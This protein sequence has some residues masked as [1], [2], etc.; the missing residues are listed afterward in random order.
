MANAII[1]R[2]YGGS[3]VL[4]LEPIDLGDPKSDEIRIRQTAIGVNYHDVYVRSG[5][6]KT[7]ALPGIPGCEATGV[8]EAVGADVQG[9]KAGDRIAYV[10]GTYGAY[11]SHRVLPAGL[12]VPLPD[13]VADTVAAS[14]LLRAMTVEML[15]AKVARV[16]A[17]M[18]ILVHAAAGGVGKMLCQV[19]ASLGVTVIGTVGSSAKAEVAQANGCAFTV[20]YREV[21][22]EKAVMDI[23]GGAGVDVIYDSVGA[24]TFAGSL[25]VLRTCGHLVNFGQSSGPVDPLTMATLAAKSLTVS[26]PILFHY[27][28]SSDTYQAMATRV[29]D[30][31]A[32][33]ILNAAE[34]TPVALKDA[35]AAHDTLENMTGGG[36][37][38][39]IP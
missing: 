10:T 35:G 21:P 12:A 22:F 31:F 32:A 8:V 11:A 1:I 33:G 7:L 5:L 28:A 30:K 2:D 36:S 39:L 4:K 23:T 27:L 34:Q 3:D 18:T 24:D 38:V 6:Y 26:R 29:F 25:E 14:N 37:L 15:T 20:L 16:E 13:G 19:L 17:G 9:L